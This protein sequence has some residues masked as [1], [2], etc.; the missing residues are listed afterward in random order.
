MRAHAVAV[1]AGE[2]HQRV[3]AVS[4]LLERGHDACH[5][6]VDLL[7][8]AVVGV[9]VDAPLVLGELRRRPQGALLLDQGRLVGRHL[10]VGRQV[11]ARAD[12]RL[13]HRPP[14]QPLPAGVL[15]DVV[16]VVERGDQEERGAA[17]RSQ[18][19]D[20]AVGQRPVVEAA[21]PGEA[22][23]VADLDLG[24]VPLAAVGAVVAG[25]RHQV[26]QL[27]RAE[28]RCD[29]L[30]VVVGADLVRHAT[31]KQAGAR[32]RAQR[33]RAVGALKAHAAFAEGVH[34]GRGQV[35]VAGGAH[36]QRGL[37]VGGDEQHVGPR[38]GT[39]LPITS[40][41]PKKVARRRCMTSSGRAGPVTA[42]TLRSKWRM[43][44]VPVITV[45][46]AGWA[47]QNL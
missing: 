15:A 43:S 12:R 36:G 39:Q 6:G 4:C 34:G 2:D 28:L 3:L 18:E 23:P 13:R 33:K 10:E 24:H 14:R 45:L 37:L 16:R 26:A 1:I 42:A 8:Q 7:D 41:T 21:D 20:A 22:M 25:G 29:R 32:R 11:R 27:A 38:G 9:A 17:R 47:A 35:R 40:V 44:L 46:T 31:G 5:L 19:V 30:V